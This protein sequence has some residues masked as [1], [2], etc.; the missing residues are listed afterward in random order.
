[1]GVNCKKFTGKQ[2]R[3]MQKMENELEKKKKAM[4]IKKG[5]K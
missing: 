5:K 1:M 2:K 3:V 4:K